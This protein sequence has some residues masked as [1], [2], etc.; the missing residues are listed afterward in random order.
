MKLVIGAD[1]RGFHMKLL[2]QEQLRK[3]EGVPLEWLDAGCFSAQRCDYPVFAAQSCKAILNGNA[4]AGILIC[5]SGIGMSMA[6]N[7][8]KGIYAGVVWNETVARVGKEHDGV[9]V[10]VIPADFISIHDAVAIAKVW[11]ETTFS[12][13]RYQKRLAMLEE[14]ATQE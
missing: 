5:G 13:G 12:G 3:L 1:H 14:L 7:R 6:A 2:L 9:N 11:L 10:L 4:Q 8:F